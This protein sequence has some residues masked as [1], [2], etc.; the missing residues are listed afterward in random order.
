[1][2]LPDLRSAHQPEHP[3]DSSVSASSPELKDPEPIIIGMNLDSAVV[4]DHNLALP[5]KEVEMVD[6]DNDNIDDSKKR[7]TDAVPDLERKSS[8]DRLSTKRAK[9]ED[10]TEIKIDESD[11]LQ[12]DE[13]NIITVD[14]KIDELPAS[15]ANKSVIA[16]ASVIEKI[17]ICLTEDE[18]L[19]DML[20]TGITKPQELTEEERRRAYR[21][22]TDQVEKKA[23]TSI[24][25]TFD[26]LKT[27]GPATDKEAAGLAP[28][29]KSVLQ[30]SR[31]KLRLS[32]SRDS[33]QKS[34]QTE[35][36]FSF[37][38]DETFILAP[39]VDFVPHPI[40]LVAT[41]PCLTECK[42]LMVELT[43]YE[44]SG[45][46]SDGYRGLLRTGS[47]GPAKKVIVKITSPGA[48]GLGHRRFT[49]VS[50]TR[51][52]LNEAQNY[53][54][55]LACLQGEVCPT[56]Y[57]LW[58]MEAKLSTRI[59]S[60]SRHKVPLSVFAAVMED[61]GEEFTERELREGRY[62]SLNQINVEHKTGITELYAK[63]HERKLVHE[64]I[65]NAHIRITPDG[66]L[67]LIDFEK[68]Y[69]GCL[70]ACWNEMKQLIL[71]LGWKQGDLKKV[72]DKGYDGKRTYDMT[73]NESSRRYMW[74]S[75]S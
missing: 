14:D 49:S 48:F 10:E 57:G 8:E 22:M 54:S 15:N 68:S 39:S 9:L 64:A 69:P 63:L 38:P 55:H 13:S 61:V 53:A 58:Y 37:M 40:S 74:H 21:V 51:K 66:R 71:Y 36:R 70:G 65:K 67:R 28:L 16:P 62:A 1:M 25:K 56:F 12:S 7:S 52:V 4:P 18:Y 33:A 47:A 41:Q 50:S 19:V 20:R 72:L 75:E 30:W 43:G 6:V 24:G 23:T 11:P 59:G 2:S 17:T 29:P 34:R 46:L 3:K 5:I 44:G 73:W 27:M 45:S 31:P 35:R 26:Y 60:Q 32:F 42:E